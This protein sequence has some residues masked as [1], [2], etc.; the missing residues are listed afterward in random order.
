MNDLRKQ[1]R[2]EQA[3]DDEEQPDDR[4]DEWIVERIV[5]AAEWSDGSAE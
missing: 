2:P 4:Q 5:L 3:N 1:E